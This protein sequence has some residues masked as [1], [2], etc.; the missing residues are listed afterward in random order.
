MSAP[1]ASKK[2][3]TVAIEK[4]TSRYTKF[5]KAAKGWLPAFIA[6]FVA[7]FAA[8]AIEFLLPIPMELSTSL[9]ALPVIAT[10]IL[11]KKSLWKTLARSVAVIVLVNVI[12]VDL[13][14]ISFVL[15][16]T[17]ILRRAWVD[18]NPG[19]EN[20]R[21]LTLHQRIKTGVLARVPLPRKN[22]SFK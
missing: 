3:K 11:V 19:G 22:A 21:L 5:R 10:V 7:V 13:A 18:G 12:Y 17:W 4:E 8:S 2:N 6:S 14:L 9:I 20:Y 1:T 15:G 16:S